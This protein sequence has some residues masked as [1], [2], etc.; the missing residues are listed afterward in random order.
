MHGLALMFLL[1]LYFSKIL[2]GNDTLFKVKPSFKFGFWLF[3]VG[4]I[5]FLITSFTILKVSRNVLNERLPENVKEYL[6]IK[7]DEINRVSNI[8]DFSSRTTLD[9][10]NNNSNKN[11]LAEE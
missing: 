4:E 2:E 3:L 11:L 9:N 7:N 1:S 5:L 10:N 6:K 8:N